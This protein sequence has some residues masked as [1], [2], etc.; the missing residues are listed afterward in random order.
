MLRILSGKLSTPLYHDLWL[1][2]AATALFIVLRKS[3]R[4]VLA[5]AFAFRL[6]ICQIDIKHM[7]DLVPHCHCGHSTKNKSKNL[8]KQLQK[9]LLAQ[10]QKRSITFACMPNQFTTIFEN[11]TTHTL[12]KSK[13][14][15]K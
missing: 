5:V 12:N 8:I 3:L 14:H 13:T 1:P 10:Q 4:A 11:T 2:P 9:H 15:L 6:R 7:C